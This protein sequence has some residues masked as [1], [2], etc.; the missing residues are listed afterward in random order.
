VKTRTGC[1]SLLCWFWLSSWNCHL[2]SDLQPLT[3]APCASLLPSGHRVSHWAG[4]RAEGGLW[5][6]HCCAWSCSVCSPWSSSS[7][8]LLALLLRVVFSAF[9]VRMVLFGWKSMIS[10]VW[11]GWVSPSWY[12][13]EVWTITSFRSSI[14]CWFVQQTCY[15]RKLVYIDWFDRFICCERK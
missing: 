3:V 10:D 5:F 8:L 1:F 2:M 12:D 15:E 7:L 4:R 11:F 13:F 6:H 14:F 9:L